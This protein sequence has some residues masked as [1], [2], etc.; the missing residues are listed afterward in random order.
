MIDEL[1][2]ISYE[3]GVLGFAEASELPGDDPFVDYM[4]E[5]C[6]GPDGPAPVR[7]LYLGTDA[8]F[9]RNQ[10]GIPTVIYG[11]GSMRVAHAADEFV[12]IAELTTAARSFA[13]LFADFGTQ[14]GSWSQSTPATR[15]AR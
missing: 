2:D 14:P 6:G 13:A 7:G 8:R 1:G 5:V 9:L 12:P 15:V 10:L 11:P 3:I 4:R